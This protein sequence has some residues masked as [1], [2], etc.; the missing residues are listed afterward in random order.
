MKNNMTL[1]QE[2][3]YLCTVCVK[4]GMHTTDYTTDEYSALRTTAP[5]TAFHLS[6][7][8]IPA[9]AFVARKRKDTAERPPEVGVL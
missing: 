9:A 2:G 7:Q 4:E 5:S 3:L 1:M 8:T 6:C